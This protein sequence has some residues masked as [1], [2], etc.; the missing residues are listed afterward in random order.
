MR[1]SVRSFALDRYNDSLVHAHELI[2]FIDISPITHVLNLHM[3]IASTWQA[4][5]E[6]FSRASPMK[7]STGI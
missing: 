7:W 6:R 4:M 5:I 2:R 3:T 1:K